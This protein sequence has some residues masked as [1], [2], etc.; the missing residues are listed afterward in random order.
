MT[1]AVNN[2]ASLSLV[3]VTVT[4][5]V[6]RNFFVTSAVMSRD[7]TIKRT[8]LKGYRLMALKGLGYQK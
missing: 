3:Q 2:K 5:L 4:A 6:H 1:L 7:L 8:D